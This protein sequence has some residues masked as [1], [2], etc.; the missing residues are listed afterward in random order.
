MILDILLITIAVWFTYAGAIKNGYVSDD[1]DGIER[2]DGKLG[3]WEYGHLIKWFFYRFC[4]KN[5]YRHH[6]FSIFMH[7]AN[8]ILLYLFLGNFFSAQVCLFTSFL[9]AVHSI[10][11]QSVAWI[12]ARGYL[13]GL[14]WALVGFNLLWT[15]PPFMPFSY[16]FPLKISII[17]GFFT[18]V[19]LLTYVLAIYGQFTTMMS[20]IILVFLGNYFLAFLGLGISFVLGMGIIKS[21][22]GYRVK[23]FKEQNLGHSTK[24]HHKKFIVA[25]KTLGYYT[26]LCIFPKRMGLYHTY[27]FHYDENLEKE[28]KMFWMGFVL[29]LT[30]IWMFFSG[31]FLIRFG[32]LWYLS[33]MVIFL[34]WITIHQFVTE[35]YCYIGNIGLCLILAGVLVN[36]PVVFALVCGLHIMRTW[37]HLPTFLNEVAFYQSNI[38]NFPDSEVAF[39]N[40]GVTYLNCGL[41]GSAMDMWTISSKINSQYDV[42]WYNLHSTVKQRGDLLRAKEYLTK[43]VSSPLCHFKEMWGKELETLEKEISFAQEANALALV[44]KGLESKPETAQKAKELLNKLIGMQKIVEVLESERKRK[45]TIIQQEESG[46]KAKEVQL[47][48][49]RETLSQPLTMEQLIQ[50][51]DSAFNVIKKETE[52]LQGVIY[53][54]QTSG[55]QV[56]NPT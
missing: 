15:I 49:I 10:N 7:N 43:A 30:M 9:F 35:R 13:L 25:M 5:P 11:T 1:K 21:V 26:Q 54:N 2:Y 33:Y 40:L 23:M 31:S 45:L 38:W 28:D 39:A 4:Q 19:Y 41:V 3:G 44:I 52:E 53:G 55:Q 50:T 34:N 17:A 37:A 18:I 24:L 14:F 16:D 27:G 48:K 32:I 6:F 46:L 22:I 36:F 20:F 56:N 42:A 8:A 47:E 29:F 51:R 12:S